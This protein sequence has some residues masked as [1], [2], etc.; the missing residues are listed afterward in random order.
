M[1]P[2]EIIYLQKKNP[3]LYMKVIMMEKKREILEQRLKNCKSKKEVNDVI[4][5]E[6]SLLQK[7]DP[8]KDIKLKVIL[9]TVKDFKKTQY[10]KTLPE[11]E[12]E[13]EK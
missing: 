12:K 3:M 1:T 8:D 5:R 2:R 10:Y 6:V 7:D 11:R 4:T 13:R 9:D